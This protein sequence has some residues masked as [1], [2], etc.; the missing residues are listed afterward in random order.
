[1]AQ[2]FGISAYVNFG[3]RHSQDQKHV[4]SGFR[5]FKDKKR[6]CSKIN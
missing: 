5:Y 2:M 4:E 1:M 6:F 3:E